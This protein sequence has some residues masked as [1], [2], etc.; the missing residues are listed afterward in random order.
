[1]NQQKKDSANKD[2]TDSEKNELIISAD[3]TNNK[4]EDITTMNTTEETKKSV[5]HEDDMKKE[6]I[7]TIV[8]TEKE[9][10]SKVTKESV[11][12]ELDLKKDVDGSDENM[13]DAKL[14]EL[15]PGVLMP[16]KEKADTEPETKNKTGLEEKV[17][18]TTNHDISDSRGLDLIAQT[19]EI[20]ENILENIPKMVQMDEEVKKD[21]TVK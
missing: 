17:S 1:M 10:K 13:M 8:D 2:V 4:K 19:V 20:T 11:T 16:S 6:I 18:D 21:S 7:K 15:K 5:S 12:E 9:I 3:I 14:N